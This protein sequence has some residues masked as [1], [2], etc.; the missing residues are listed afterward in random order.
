[1]R[2]NDKQYNKDEKESY[3]CKIYTNTINEKNRCFWMKLQTEDQCC[4][5]NATGVSIYHDALIK[6]SLY[7]TNLLGKVR[8]PIGHGWEKAYQ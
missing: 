1:M 7:Q 6:V 4:C 2:L 3:Q 5:R 8:V